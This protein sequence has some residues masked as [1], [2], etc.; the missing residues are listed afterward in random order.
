MACSRRTFLDMQKSFLL[1]NSASNF[2]TINMVEQNYWDG[3]PMGPI[4]DEDFENILNGLDLPME[5]LEEAGLDK[6]WD[7]SVYQLFGPIPS[8][9]LM[10]LPL[11]TVNGCL[12]AHMTN[13]PNEFPEAQGNVLFQRRSPISVLENS[14]SCSGGRN[15]PFNFGTKGRRSKRV[16][17]STLSP[18]ILMPPLPRTTFAAKKNSDAKRVKERRKLS[19]AMASSLFRRCTHCEV[20]K[21]PQWREGPLGPKTLCNACGVRYRSGRLLPEYRPAASPTFIPSL[22]SNSHRKVVEM[23]R[24]T[25]EESPQWDSQN[26]VPLNNYMFNTY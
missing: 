14:R 2:L 1:P 5:S 7:D 17:S 10:T 23:R 11:D 26:F 22:H 3:T 21:T 25:V 16:R 18:W 12:D 15:A 8:D 20:T 9:A 24:K 13:A 4:V 19:G 6:D